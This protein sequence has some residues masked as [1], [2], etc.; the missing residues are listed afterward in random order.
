MVD[1]QA[2]AGRDEV[3]V[4]MEGLEAGAEQA[5]IEQQQ[6]ARTIRTMLRERGRG[7][8]W[9]AIFDRETS[10]SAL[11]LLA[12]SLR[13]LTELSRGFRAALAG[14]LR[15]EGLSTRQIASRLDVTHQRVSAMLKSQRP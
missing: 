9:S 15:S 11:S 3:Y 7:R 14:A 5:A 12:S 4:A 2:G 13:R 8:S 6:L 10:P 1:T